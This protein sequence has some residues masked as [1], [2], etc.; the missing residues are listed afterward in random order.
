LDP[1]T[2]AFQP[3]PHYLKIVNVVN[4]I[5]VYAASVHKHL[6]ST[7]L[8]FCHSLLCLPKPYLCSR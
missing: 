2:T 1:V 4:Q 3:A 6:D 5:L 7:Q 8:R